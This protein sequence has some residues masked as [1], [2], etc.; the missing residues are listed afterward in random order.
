MDEEAIIFQPFHPDNFT[1]YNKTASKSTCDILSKIERWGNAA[2][3]LIAI[4]RDGM[5]RALMEKSIACQRRNKG[6][7]D[8]KKEE[9]MV[10]R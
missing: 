4:D 1:T 3:V 5:C 8:Q 10:I 9:M 6:K 7:E 2:K